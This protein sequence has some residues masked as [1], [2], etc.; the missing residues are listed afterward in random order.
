MNKTQRYARL[1]IYCSLAV[2][3]NLIE[4]L[5]LPPLY[6]GIRFG[7][8]NIISLITLKQMGFKDM[9]IVVF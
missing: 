4:N 3:I 5:F 7:L 8:A 6:F 9:C 2:V 1:A